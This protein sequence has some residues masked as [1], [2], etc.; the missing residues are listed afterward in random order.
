MT[1][2][3]RKR[4]LADNARALSHAGMTPTSKVKT[5]GV[6]AKVAAAAGHPDPEATP[7]LSEQSVEERRKNAADLTKD[8]PTYEE[9]SP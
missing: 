9:E 1:D 5:T 4:I 8:D 3:D 2:A 7:P 6:K